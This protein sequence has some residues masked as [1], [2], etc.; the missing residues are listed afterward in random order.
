MTDVSRRK[1]GETQDAHTQSKGYVMTTGRGHLSV[2][3]GKQ[4]C[5][6]FYLGLPTSTTEK[7][8]PLLKPH[9][10]WYFVIAVPAE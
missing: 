9:S 8:L 5:P 3:E 2:M 7:K 1:K 4:V 6:Y 10:L